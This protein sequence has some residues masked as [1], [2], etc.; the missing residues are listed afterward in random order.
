MFLLPLALA[1][2]MYS[3]ALEFHPVSTRNLGQLVEPPVQVDIKTLT[4][5]AEEVKNLDEL[6]DH[7][8]VLHVVP[9]ECETPCKSEIAGLRQVHRAAGRNQS[10]VRMVMLLRQD[11][12]AA[13]LTEIYASFYL[14]ETSDGMFRASLDDIADR[15][16]AAGNSDGSTYLIDP[17]GNIMMYYDSGFDP[18]DLKNDLKRLLTWSK[19][20]EQ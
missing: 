1:W 9:E 18:N 7:W 8:V 12:S 17:L 16:A 13:G 4:S 19:L 11:Q 14:A 10:R 15:Y 5:A 2:L 6:D 20:D 3:G